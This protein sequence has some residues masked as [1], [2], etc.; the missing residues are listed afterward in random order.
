MLAALLSFC[1]S[2]VASET[3]LVLTPGLSV[4]SGKEFT[5][6]A[7]I[8]GT[9][10]NVS[11][12]WSMLRGP[13]RLRL[14][15]RGRTASLVL[16]VKWSGEYVFRCVATAQGGVSLSG[17][18]KVLVTEQ[19]FVPVAVI[20][21]DL[22][23]KV[24]AGAVVFISGEESRDP[25]GRDISFNWSQVSGTTARVRKGTYESSVLEFVPESPGRYVFA[26]QVSAGRDRSE[27]AIVIVEVPAR[28]DGSADQAPVISI[29]YPEIATLNRAVLLD[30]AGT[31]DPDK[32][33]VSISWKLIKGPDSVTFDASGTSV[34][35]TPVKTGAYLFRVT[36]Q[37]NGLDVSKE[38]SVRVTGDSPVEPFKPDTSANLCSVDFRTETLDDVLV[39]LSRKLGITI[40]I[41]PRWIN[42]AEYSK[43]FVDL[44]YDKVSEG[45]LVTAV[46]RII[47]GRY[48]VEGR[49]AYW[50]EKNYSFLREE[51]KETIS[52]P[53]SG[54]DE[55]KIMTWA[56]EESIKPAMLFG[57]GKIGPG[58]DK[59]S[60]VGILPASAVR[61]VK[62]ILSLA[63]APKSL[64][65]TAI[66]T[67]VCP[68]LMKQVSLKADE[69]FIRDVIW[70]IASQAGVNIGFKPSGLPDMGRKLI[71][72]DAGSM[73]LADA[74]KKIIEIAGLDSYRI[75]SPNVV[76][77]YKTDPGLS[78]P[79]LWDSS[80]EQAF[81]LSQ[82]IH[83]K[84]LTASLIEHLI[85]NRVEPASWNDP[86][87]AIIYLE[88]SE[89]LIIV[90]HPT[91]I[92][93]V[94]S[95]LKDLADSGYRFD[96]LNH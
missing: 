59:R 61:R 31:Q 60:V 24:G 26:L 91:V 6:K 47:G 40:R 84:N 80:A 21:G 83:K 67:P 23:R 28:K 50:I 86:A 10:G 68:A 85:K 42:P 55:I 8:T 1:L 5:L 66:G 34:R 9:D 76:W 20:S 15:D 51:T 48:R 46:A 44:K 78:G 35:F 3:K 14:P 75:D 90:N 79:N 82:L 58:N 71:T 77:L 88:A 70:D 29:D 39:S 74:L 19:S 93:L 22:V 57:D 27:P 52:I 11:Y 2:G 12:Q 16:T 95:F 13:V 56:L 63:S 96:N 17:E 94:D 7:E 53:A 41:D 64:P 4:P 87:T 32:D 69:L 38:F 37:S 54:P 36:A 72:I 49:H 62:N 25:A 81:D 18:T 45:T 43:I 30:A 89:R 65:P 92:G 33:D 73:T